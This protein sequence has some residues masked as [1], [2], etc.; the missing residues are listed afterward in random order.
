MCT[1]GS[2][3]VVIVRDGARIKAGCPRLLVSDTVMTGCAVTSNVINFLR[4]SPVVTCRILGPQEMESERK[5][6]GPDIDSSNSLLFWQCSSCVQLKRQT[7]K[8]FA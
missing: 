1:L 8:V 4:C 3:T 7:N 2:S 6:I 5:K